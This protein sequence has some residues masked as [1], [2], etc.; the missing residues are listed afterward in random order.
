MSCDTERRPPY[1]RT[2]DSTSAALLALLICGIGTACGPFV[3]WGFEL[4]DVD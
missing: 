4:L 1:W 3:R 2:I